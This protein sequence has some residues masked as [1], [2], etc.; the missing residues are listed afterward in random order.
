MLVQKYTSADISYC[1]SLLKS[2][3]PTPVEFTTWICPLI[4]GGSAHIFVNLIV[5]AKL[6][7]QLKN[8]KVWTGSFY[9]LWP[10]ANKWLSLKFL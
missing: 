3:F 6:P 10:V 8:L 9:V 4:L 5:L 2:G 7:I 1:I